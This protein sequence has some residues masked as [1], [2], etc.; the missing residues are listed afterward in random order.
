VRTP[1]AA[2]ALAHDRQMHPSRHLGPRSAAPSGT[3]ELDE[4]R[5]EIVRLNARLDAVLRDHGPVPQPVSTRSAEEAT[6]SRRQLLKLAG[7]AAVA[8][9]AG[10]AVDSRPAA[11]ATGDSL[12]LGYTNFAT[13]LTYLTNGQDP[14]FPLPP[15]NSLTTEITLM[16][17]DHRS[18]PLANSVGLRGDGR[19]NGIGLNGFGGTGVAG[20]GTT[21]G[22]NANGPIGVNTT[23]VTHGII[24]SGEIG[25]AGSGTTYGVVASGV[26]GVDSTGTT[27]GMNAT[28]P[29]GIN[30]T[31][32]TNGL[33]ATG[34]VGV[35]ATG[36]THGVF[37]IGEVGALGSGDDVGVVGVGAGS[38]AVGVSASGS[39]AALRLTP[40]TPT[41]TPPAMRIDAHLA[42]EIDIDSAANVW[43]CVASGS[44]GQWR[45]IAGPA[46]AGAFH[47]FNPTRVFDS[48]WPGNA[49]LAGGLQNVVSVADGRDL[50]GVVSALNL[51]PAGATAIAFNLTI[52]Q[53]V[54]SGYLSVAPGTA[55]AV[56]ASSIN[57]SANNQDIAN[58]LIVAIDDTRR[59]KVFGGGGGS[60]HYIVDVAGY[61]L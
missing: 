31:G 30:S 45:K 14:V 61:F 56:T 16:W 20:S 43:L 37:A 40:S 4:L 7:A 48:R 17:A 18:S 51:V 49:P 50:S 8:A 19:E 36:T 29:I 28:G 58:G 54:G 27:V 25:V 60:A 38:S 46:T 32:T 3:S 1:D 6:G 52:S 9:A 44:P 59:I 53:T 42:G 47:A 2:A 39:R 12:R 24:A 21:Y 34:A 35:S 15:S 33:V 10:A 55:T 5:E 23:G 11:A 41:A 57:W 26:I 13:N 22:V